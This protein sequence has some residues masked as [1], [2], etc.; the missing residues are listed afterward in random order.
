[1]TTGDNLHAATE[2]P[3]KD[4]EIKE[5]GLTPLAAAEPEKA[6]VVKTD[7]EKSPAEGSD[8]PSQ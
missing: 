4:S 2:K 3:L 5:L 6:K 8:P 7:V 1:L